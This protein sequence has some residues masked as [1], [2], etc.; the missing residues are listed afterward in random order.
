[1]VNTEAKRHAALLVPV[2]EAARLLG[3][4]STHAWDLARRGI[5]PTVRLGRSV[6]VPRA[7]I[8][9]LVAKAM[10]AAPEHAKGAS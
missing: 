9:D 1:M 5:L 2:P 8:D 10:L 6:R 4:G 3:I 7:H